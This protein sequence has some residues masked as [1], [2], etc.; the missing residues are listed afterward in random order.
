MTGFFCFVLLFFCCLFFVF[1]VVFFL[2][3]VLFCYVF[4]CAFCVFF[5]FSFFF[6]FFFW[7]GGGGGVC[8]LKKNTNSRKVQG[9]IVPISS[10]CG[11]SQFQIKICIRDWK[12]LKEFRTD[13]HIVFTFIST[14]VSE[15]QSNAISAA[16]KRKNVISF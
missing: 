2:V 7:G 15:E 13:N 11:C 4:V 14:F 12:Y 1:F 16:C 10:A 9:S 6:F 3:F 5:S 8:T